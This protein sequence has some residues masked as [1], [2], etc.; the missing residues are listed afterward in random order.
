MDSIVKNGYDPKKIVMGL[1]AG[2]TYESEL[3]DMYE[4]YKD[5]FGGLFVWEYFNTVPSAIQWC[6]FVES[7][8]NHTRHISNFCLIS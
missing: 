2:E 7:V 1:I 6:Q 3:Q 8:F 5:N 4:K